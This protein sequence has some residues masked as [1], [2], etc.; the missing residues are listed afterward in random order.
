[1]KKRVNQKKEKWQRLG[2]GKSG[3]KSLKKIK[4]FLTLYTMHTCIFDINK[5]KLKNFNKI[6]HLGHYSMK[7][8]INQVD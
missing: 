4:A 1:M 3:N 2:R 6:K 8:D 7:Y 5:N